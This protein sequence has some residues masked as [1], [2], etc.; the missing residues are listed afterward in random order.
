MAVKRFEVALDVARTDGVVDFQASYRNFYIV[1][2]D[3]DF[4]FKINSDKADKIET[5]EIKGFEGGV[6]ASRLYITN[7][8][9]AAGQK[10]VILAW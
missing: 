8:A 1:R 3:A 2:N 6:V 5:T 4:S 9:A 10:A 7:T